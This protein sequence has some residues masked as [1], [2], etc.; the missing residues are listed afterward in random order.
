MAQRE[1]EFA[2]KLVVIT[3]AAS[4]IGE[5]TALAFA[6][7]G[8][9]LELADLDEA[10]LSRVAREAERR[11]ALRA[12]GSEVDVADEAGVRGFAERVHASGAAVDVLVNNA[13]VG[14]AGGFL[15]TSVEDWAWMLGVN[16]WGVIHTT[17]AFAPP[18]LARRRGQIINVASA[19][20]FWNPSA[21]GA[22]GT[23]KYALF[24]LSE[25]LRQDFSER[26]VG[27]SVVCPGVV[28]TPLVDNLRLRGRYSGAN[29][30]ERLRAEVGRHGASREAVAAAIVHAARANSAVVPVALQGWGLYLLKRLTPSLLPA[31]FRRWTAA[32]L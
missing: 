30:R 2:G 15:D 13:G 4:G 7:R 11:G 29:S 5:A 28:N 21:L 17:R 26:G 8:A 31:L 9:A 1:S 25:A 22:Y 12:R 10:G 18:M 3:G 14:V 32:E 16:L 24:G 6:E 19:A 27:V 23:T 20:A